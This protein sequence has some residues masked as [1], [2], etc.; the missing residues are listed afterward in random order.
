MEQEVEQ[1]YVPRAMVPEAKCLILGIRPNFKVLYK[2]LK[3]ID[4]AIGTFN[5]SG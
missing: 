3:R 2:S 1:V 4:W 5:R